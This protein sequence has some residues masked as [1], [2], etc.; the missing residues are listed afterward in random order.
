MLKTMSFRRS[1][2]PGVVL[3]L[4]LALV[5]AACPAEEPDADD[6]E[7]ADG[8]PEQDEATG[9]QEVDD[10]A[11]FPTGGSIEIGLGSPPD[12]EQALLVHNLREYLEEE[13]GTSLAFRYIT[14]AGHRVITE[15]THSEA[16]DDGYFLQIHAVPVTTTGQVYFDGN[17]DTEEFE[18]IINMTSSNQHV[19]VLEDSEF[20][21]LDD[22]VDAGREGE[23]QIATPGVGTSNHLVIEML[24]AGLDI[25]VVPIHYDGGGEAV[26]ALMGGH[27]DFAV[28]QTHHLVPRE[29]DLRILAHVMDERHDRWPDVET[30]EEQGYDWV[31]GQGLA[32]NFGV[33]APPG[34]PEDRFETLREAF[35][36][37]MEQEEVLAILDDMGLS[38]DIRVGE[39][40]GQLISDSLQVLEDFREVIEPALDE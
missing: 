10:E 19:V 27:T 29:D 18:P 23:L 25:N 20:E 17:Y 30:V 15:Y 35:A 38:P 5:L 11:P 21:T 33:V 16:R 9:D 7:A 28:L 40:Y 39:E 24:A 32:L 12:S 37:V 1:R 14:G 2:W 4:T 8:P 34:T 26:A 13:L 22:L 31:E 6:V 36:N 3:L